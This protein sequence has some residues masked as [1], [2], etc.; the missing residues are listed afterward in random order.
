MVE[1]KSDLRPNAACT[2]LA[3]AILDMEPPQRG[4]LS[5]AAPFMVTP[6]GEFVATSLHVKHVGKDLWMPVAMWEKIASETAANRDVVA[7]L[8]HPPAGPPGFWHSSHRS[9]R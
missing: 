4:N 7:S 8:L 6:E 2:T 5:L 9:F 3:E 1:I